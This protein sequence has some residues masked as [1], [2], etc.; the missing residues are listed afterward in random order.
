M[1]GN[2]SKM[3]D[4]GENLETRILVR[5]SLSTSR[6]STVSEG[7]DKQFFIKN[8]IISNKMNLCVTTR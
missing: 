6:S 1:G 4:N 2:Y 5:F 3:T 8:K 7:R